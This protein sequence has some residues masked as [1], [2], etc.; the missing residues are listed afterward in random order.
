VPVVLARLVVALRWPIVLAWAAALVLA[1]PGMPTIGQ[2][3]GGAV[4]EA[5]PEDADAV[6]AEVLE[7]R[8]FGVPLS[9]RVLLV[10]RDPAGLPEAEQRRF[11]EAAVRAKA[12][13]L[14]G[15]RDVVPFAREDAT[16]AVAYVPAPPDVSL[17]DQTAAAHRLA[18]A[19]GLA[20]AKVTGVIPARLEATDAIESRL[21][22]VEL[23]TALLVALVVGWHFRAPGPPLLTLLLVGTAY[24][25]AIRVVPWAAERTGTSAP[26]E[27]EP[28]ITVLV[29]GAVTDYVIFYLSR[30]R[31]ALARGATRLDAAREAAASV[32]G[33]VTVAA[34]IV[35]AAALA[36]GAS[37]FAFFRAFG[38][39]MAV[40]V[41]VGW[42]V[43]VTL[44]PAALA[45]G[46]ARLFRPCLPTEE[47]ADPGP[48]RRRVMAGV[49]RVPALVAL[50]CVLALGAGAAGLSQLVLE[51]PA[52]SGLAA[53]SEE[54]EAE[55]DLARGI[56]PG[57]A[58]P[59][60]VLLTGPQAGRDREALARLQERLEA[61]PGVLA[62]LG[63]ADDPYGALGGERGAAAAAAAEDR[64]AARAAAAAS[65]ALV[66][67]DGRAARMALVLDG[68]PLGP[69][70]VEHE[71]AG[72]R[73]A[74]VL[75]AGQTALAAEATRTV[76]LDALRVG[77]LVLL[78][79]LLALALYLRALA[80]PAL[81]LAAGVL[82]VAAALGI[83]AWFWA[84]VLDD[85]GLSYVTPFAAAV[86]LLALGSD[87][88]VL[89]AGRIWRAARTA[90]PRA[91]IA[92]AAARASRPIGVAALVLAAS[93]ALLAVVPLQDLRQ[94]AAVMAVGLLLDA[95]V[96]RTLLVPALVAL[97]ARRGAKPAGLA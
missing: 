49:V 61:R 81:L 82:G 86:L 75:L 62:V 13:P 69:D 40:T 96:V 34:L 38:P 23:A 32:A 2:S 10:R 77:P 79:V 26:Q 28:V 29:F 97:V 93:F 16:T 66:R 27:V 36:L 30:A 25:L 72:V 76:A 43:V 67:E 24:L 44:A 8:A 59:V 94:L 90:E 21:W 4:G 1:I 6:R 68:D 57:M 12:L 89:L 7:A 74:E 50:V 54:R 80:V 60:T 53:D 19:P 84:A 85:P 47:E 41:L 91:A 37:S 92:D 55:A 78:V 11:V 45:I 73:D 20:P 65:E 33:P 3:G 64:P 9:A 95:F 58:A 56:A 35:C 51:E 18:R 48:A 31:V 5:V 14:V 22:I 63:P 87:Y 52:V 83:T 39:G 15:R 42:A 46:G 88:N 70:A 71:A 17:T